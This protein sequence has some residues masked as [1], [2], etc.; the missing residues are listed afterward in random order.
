MWQRY[1]M[2]DGYVRLQARRLR[3]I[4]KYFLEY[5]CKTPASIAGNRTEIRSWCLPNK[6]TTVPLHRPLWCRCMKKCSDKHIETSNTLNACLQVL[7]HQI[8]RVID[9]I[10]H[11]ETLTLV[12]SGDLRWFAK[13]K[14]HAIPQPKLF[15]FK[16][17][18]A[19]RQCTVIANML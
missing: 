17:Y 6:Y 3:P 10:S 15:N 1:W 14:S 4:S 2:N 13:E 19:H 9:Q 18:L 7:K 11:L 16:V 5:I 8:F 12:S